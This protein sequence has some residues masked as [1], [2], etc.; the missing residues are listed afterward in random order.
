VRRASPGTY[1]MREN[2]LA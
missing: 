2:K 1:A